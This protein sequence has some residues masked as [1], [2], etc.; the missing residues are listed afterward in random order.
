MKKKRV[1]I[2]IIAI[3]VMAIILFI[4]YKNKHTIDEKQ[5]IAENSYMNLAWGFSYSGTIIC[6]D[7]SVYKFSI[8]D[9][10][11]EYIDAYKDLKKLNKCILNNT[12]KYVCKISKNEIN[13]IKEYSKNIQNENYTEESSGGADMGQNSI[14]IWNYETNERIT[15]K[16]SGDWNGKNSS[17][18]ANELIYLIEKYTN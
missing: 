14:K 16:T 11:N 12:T 1:I 9:N 17:L 3:L 13:K 6:N 5:I 10:N 15:L 2:T 8:T 7:G 4:V 18:N